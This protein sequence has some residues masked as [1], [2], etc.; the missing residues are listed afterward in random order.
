MSCLFFASAMVVTTSLPANALMP[1]AD[2]HG[3]STRLQTIALGGLTQD[4][5]VGSTGSPTVLRDGFSVTSAAQAFQSRYVPVN[6]FTND[7]FGTI[8]WPFAVGVPITSP[9][10]W[11]ASPCYGCSNFHSGVDLAPGGFGAPIG[12][13]AD[14]I[15]TVARNYEPDLGTE[16]V[17]DHVINGQKVQSVY[18]HMELG[19]IAVAVGQRVKVGQLVGKV[20]QTGV[21]TGP[22][23]HLEIL[24]NGT[25]VDPM[26]W[27]RRNA[28]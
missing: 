19:S 22:H 24:V 17:I 8:Q 25:L 12:A 10:G 16:V 1:L 6:T 21:A 23:L 3:V 5:V 7:P 26:A 11:R 9:F 20:G 4:V 2:N 15:V 14:G 13:I 28:N 27:L 18:G